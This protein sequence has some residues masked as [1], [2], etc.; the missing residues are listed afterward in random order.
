MTQFKVKRSKSADT[1]NKNLVFFASDHAG[2]PLRHSIIRWFERQGYG[3]IDCGPKTIQPGDDYPQLA[4]AVSQKLLTALAE[5]PEAKGVLLCGSGVGMAMM[6]NRFKGI[7]A[8]EGYSPEQVRLARE[9][10]NANILTLGA[11]DI[12]KK[13]AE[14]LVKKF[15]ETKFTPIDRHQRRIKQLDDLSDGLKI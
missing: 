12:S 9:H 6:A 2:W 3:I 1:N 15:F 11:R 4:Q 5:Q 10:N 8:V 7:R 13:L 14:R